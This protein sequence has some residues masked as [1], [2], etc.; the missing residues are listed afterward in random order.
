MGICST[1]SGL[2]L[3]RAIAGQ[4]REDKLDDRSFAGPNGDP[5][6]QPLIPALL[7]RDVVCYKCKLM[8]RDELIKRLKEAEPALRQFGVSALYLFGSVARGEAA[9]GSDVDV[10]VDPASDEAFGFLNYMDAYEAIRRSVGEGIELGYSTRD[11]LSP[12]I[13]GSVEREAIRIF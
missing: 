6:P 3:P 8:Q 9:P 12:Y 10:F 4:G 5:E 11:G 7:G 13:R 1:G 2:A